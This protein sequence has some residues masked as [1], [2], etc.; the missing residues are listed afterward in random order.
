MQKQITKEELQTEYPGGIPPEFDPDKLPNL[1]RHQVVFFDE[2]HVEQEGGPSYQTKYQIRFPRDTNGKY[3][4]LSP[5]NPNPI[6]AE[7]RNKPSFK[8]CQQACFCLGCAAME[9]PDGRI[10]D[11]RTRVFDY[12]GQRLVSIG[13]YDRRVRDEINRVKTLKINGRRSK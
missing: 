7:I 2:M 8:Y 4:P 1:S 11:K 5:T 10:V 6:F 9:L 12:T 13:E 3:C